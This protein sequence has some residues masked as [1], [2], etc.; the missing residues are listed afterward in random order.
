MALWK[1]VS[2]TVAE[3]G[4]YAKFTQHAD[5]RDALLGTGDMVLVEASPVD[6]V[7]GIGLNPSDPMALD[8]ECWRGMNLS[9]RALMRVRERLFLNLLTV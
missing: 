1:K 7:W 8:P 9:G 2:L 4:W 5:L 6:T 3:R